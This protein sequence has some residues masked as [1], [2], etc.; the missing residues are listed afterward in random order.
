MVSLH[1]CFL[2]QPVQEP[3][4][5]RIIQNHHRFALQHKKTQK[6]TSLIRFSDDERAR[7]LTPARRPS[8]TFDPPVDSPSSATACRKKKSSNFFHKICPRKTTFFAQRSELS[9][10]LVLTT[11]AEN[12]R[13][14]S[15]MRSLG[16]GSISGGS[17][18]P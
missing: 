9:R 5:I 16:F 4:T 10:V 14:T 17:H 2:L 3:L 11:V 7:F 12:A 1:H 13:R 15:R 6:H 18:E 8:E